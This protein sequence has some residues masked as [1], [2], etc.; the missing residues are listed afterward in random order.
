MPM[1]HAADFP[2]KPV[3]LLVGFGPGGGVD[4]FARRIAQ[5]L[6]EK[7]GQPVVVVNKAGA[8]ASLAADYV[9]HSAPNGYTLLVA[10]NAQSVKPQNPTYDPVDSFSP[11][12]LAASN[13]AVLLVHPS[14]PANN[15]K[16]LIALAK[17]KPGTLNFGNP[18][19]GGTPFMATE[20]LIK[21]T[22]IDLVG[23]P[24]NGGGPA[25]V[26]LLG[27]ETQVLFGTISGAGE[28]VKA[29]KVKALAVST[30]ERSPSMP[31]LPT[32]AEAGDLPGFNVI[33]WFG[34][35]APANTPHD[36]VM[37]IHDDIKAI[38]AMPDVQTALTKDDFKV[39]GSSPEE[40]TAFLRKD[41][42]DVADLLKGI[43]S[44]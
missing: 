24:F 25:L 8:D 5:K 26:S 40:F 27:G 33:G 34:I 32:V 2:T 6:T 30:I 15:L 37:K 18:G 29:G 31:E 36:V 11:I 17:S 4:L 41:V 21:R 19:V 22:G 43:Q 16:E 13:G 7:W 35:M 3:Q 42:V 38:L 23:V 44:H 39:V 20:T 12:I 9:A 1:S 10:S 14:V 28:L